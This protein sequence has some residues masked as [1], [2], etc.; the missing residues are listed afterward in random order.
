MKDAFFINNPVN[1]GRFDVP[2][3]S[4]NSSNGSDHS[5]S[6]AAALDVGKKFTV[7]NA[8]SIT[9]H[10][11]FEY[12]YKPSTETRSIYHALHIY[13][14]TV[15]EAARYPTSTVNSHQHF[16]EIPIGVK[17]AKDFCVGTTIITPRLDLALVTSLGNM[18]ESNKNLYVG[19]SVYNG[20][21]WKTFGIAGDHVGGRAKIG[22]DAHINNRVKLAF[23]YTFE[24][25]K[26]YYDHRLS[27]TV[28]L[29]F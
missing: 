23:D 18:K 26:K 27:A 22:L 16:F 5:V 17:F 21:E 25:R 2:N 15:Y 9:P 8:F 20:R 19:Q 3:I 1:P 28:G 11:G 6:F 29:S 10:I 7:L 14:G 13:N 4:A 24:G 12:A